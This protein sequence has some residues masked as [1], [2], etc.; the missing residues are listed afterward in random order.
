MVCGNQEELRAHICRVAS[1]KLDVDADIVSLEFTQM[2]ALGECPECQIS[3]FFW[4]FFAPSIPINHGLCEP[5]GVESSYWQ[6]G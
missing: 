1:P 3:L 4:P 2:F 6:G 5:G